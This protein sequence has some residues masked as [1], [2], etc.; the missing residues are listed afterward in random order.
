MKLSPHDRLPKTPEPF[1]VERSILWE[2]HNGYMRLFIVGPGMNAWFPVTKAS[3]T[4]THHG[5]PKER[6]IARKAIA[7]LSIRFHDN[8]EAGPDDIRKAL[9]AFGWKP[10]E[11]TTYPQNP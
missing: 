3:S 9:E 7:S 8:R 6:E 4:V 10:D 1:V 2:L 5:T 11:L